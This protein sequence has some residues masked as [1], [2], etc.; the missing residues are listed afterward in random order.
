MHNKNWNCDGD[1]CTHE[2]AEIRILPTGGSS[3]ALL[4]RACFNHELQYRKQRNKELGSAF[5]FDIPD[6]YDLK[7]YDPG[8]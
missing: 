2:S 1:H 3:N 4:C 7:L 6:W 8:S 5:K